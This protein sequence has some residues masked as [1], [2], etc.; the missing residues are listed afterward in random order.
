MTLL[1][2]TGNCIKTQILSKIFLSNTNIVSRSAVTKNLLQHYTF[3][4]ILAN[5]MFITI[6][7]QFLITCNNKHDQANQACHAMAITILHHPRQIIRV[8]SGSWTT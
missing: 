5:L 2:V 1:P 8:A 6:I 3:Q 7:K 4:E